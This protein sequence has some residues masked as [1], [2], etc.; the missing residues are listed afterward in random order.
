MPGH[1]GTA[2]DAAPADSRA[3]AGAIS[4][5]TIRYVR[6]DAVMSYEKLV[7]CAGGVFGN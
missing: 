2:Q 3:V 5:I 7:G 6:H 4:T 1:S